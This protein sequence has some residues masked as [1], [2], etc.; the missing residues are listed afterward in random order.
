MSDVFRMTHQSRFMPAW[1]RQTRS[2][3]RCATNEMVRSWLTPPQE[4]HA[5]QVYA[6]AATVIQSAT[7]SLRTNAS[8][9]C[10]RWDQRP[11]AGSSVPLW[12]SVWDDQYRTRW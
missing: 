9:G 11:W 5:G 12:R 7:G 4:C 1:R 3:L 6:S 8:P 2:L 10:Q